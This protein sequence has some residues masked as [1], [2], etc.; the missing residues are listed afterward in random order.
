MK[1]H[2]LSLLIR[3]KSYSVQFFKIHRSYTINREYIRLFGH[4]YVELTTGEKVPMTKRNRA[5][6]INSLMDCTNIQS[7]IDDDAKK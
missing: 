6:L 3:W 7:G 5:Q 1:L 4:D 2:V